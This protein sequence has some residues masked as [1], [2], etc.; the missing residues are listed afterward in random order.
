MKLPPAHVPHDFHHEGKPIVLIE[1]YKVATFWMPHAVFVSNAPKHPQYFAEVDFNYCNRDGALFYHETGGGG[2][3]VNGWPN[4]KKL[5][6]KLWWNHELAPGLRTGGGDK[7]T[8]PATLGFEL[9]THPLKLGAAEVNPFT[10]GSEGEVLYCTKCKDHIPEDHPCGHVF[11][12]EKCHVW[13]GAASDKER[14]RH[15]K[16]KE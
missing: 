11:W 2:L 15:R 12:C 13:G 14:C 5:H 4:A 3:Y 10:Y 8:D 16:P 1:Y 6:A 7:V 9:L